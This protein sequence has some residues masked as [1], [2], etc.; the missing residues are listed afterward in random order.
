M[1]FDPKRFLGADECPRAAHAT[2]GGGSHICLGQPL[3]RVEEPLALA[4]ATSGFVLELQK[5][6]S[7]DARLTGVV[8]PVER[9]IPVRVRRRRA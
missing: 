8:S 3:A 9:E 5:P 6:V 1:R 7:L 2:F 4:I